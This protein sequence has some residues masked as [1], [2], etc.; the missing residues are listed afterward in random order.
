MCLEG[1]WQNDVWGVV[2]NFEEA[3]KSID[4]QKRVA[5]KIWPTQLKGKEEEE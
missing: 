2:H 5:A 4:K 1:R 3:K